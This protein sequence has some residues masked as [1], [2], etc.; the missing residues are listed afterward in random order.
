MSIINEEI[1][2]VIEA[3]KL[4]LF[5]MQSLLDYLGKENLMLK[6]IVVN[7]LLDKGDNTDEFKTAE[8]QFANSFSLRF[9]YT[10]DDRLELE[11]KK[12]E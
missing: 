8:L 5:S 6:A 4:A 10:E 1:F 7:Y 11:I 2:A 9:N 12:D 3:S